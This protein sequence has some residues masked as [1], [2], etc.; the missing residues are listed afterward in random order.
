MFF[1]DLEE[2]RFL[3]GLDAA[4]GPVMMDRSVFAVSGIRAIQTQRRVIMPNFEFSKDRRKALSVLLQYAECE[5]LELKETGL[6]EIIQA[7]YRSMDPPILP[8]QNDILRAPWNKF[9]S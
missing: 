5:A 3:T 8:A 6:A 4:F 7:A 9:Q 2:Q 1:Y